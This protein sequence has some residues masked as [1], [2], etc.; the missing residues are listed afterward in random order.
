[1]YYNTA[2]KSISDSASKRLLPTISNV[3]S[4]PIFLQ[5]SWAGLLIISVS[6]GVWCTENIYFLEYFNKG[7]QCLLDLWIQRASRFY[8]MYIVQL[9][10]LVSSRLGVLRG[11]WKQSNKKME[12][13]I[14]KNKVNTKYNYYNGFKYFSWCHIVFN[15]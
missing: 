6:R 2:T 11:K 3:Q 8:V 14:A 10:V 12:Q 7:L 15:C 9:I 4:I 5:V 1:M 13:N